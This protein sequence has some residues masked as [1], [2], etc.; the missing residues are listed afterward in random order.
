MRLL[1]RLLLF[2]SVLNLASGH[3][4]AEGAWIVDQNKRAF[5][6]CAR[7]PAFSGT[8]VAY[9][10]RDREWVSF[11]DNETVFPTYRVLL[12]EG[13]TQ[14][15]EWVESIEN[16][17]RQH[18]FDIVDV[19]VPRPESS[20]GKSTD[21]NR[22]WMAAT[23]TLAFRLHLIDP[24]ILVSVG[25]FCHCDLRQMMYSVGPGDAYE[26]GK[27][28]YSV[29]LGSDVFWWDSSWLFPINLT[30]MV[31]CFVFAVSGC[32]VWSQRYASYGTL[33]TSIRKEEIRMAIATSLVFHFPSLV[34]LLV[35]MASMKC[36][37]LSDQLASLLVASVAC[38]AFSTIYIR[39]CDAKSKLF[40]AMSCFWAAV[41]LLVASVVTTYF[42]TPDAYEAYLDI[43]ALQD[44]PVPVWVVNL[45]Q[46][47]GP[48]WDILWNYAIRDFGLDYVTL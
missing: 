25:A 33:G 20:W 39:S 36:R 13:P 26:R 17:T 18:T 28:M 7:Y 8:C 31:L 43:M 34:T 32:H 3:L 27:L 23:T 46:R 14:T 11:I 30:C 9:S 41:F 44:R 4:I 6:H 24:E 21:F 38:L 19:G 40:L 37:A 1:Y 47:S 45:T 15:R 2:L 5:L 16:L 22:D 29:Q 10:A 12:W 48:T 35:M 42:L